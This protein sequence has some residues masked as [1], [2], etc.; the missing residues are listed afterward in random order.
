MHL[1]LGLKRHR[2]SFAENLLVAVSDV[3]SIFV[4]NFSF[5]FEFCKIEPKEFDRLVI[6]VTSS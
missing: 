3:L 5:L 2:T 6:S 4:Y 1:I